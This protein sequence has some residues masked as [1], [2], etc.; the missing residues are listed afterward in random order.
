MG[1][2]QDPAASSGGARARARAG[3]A[4]PGAIPQVRRRSRPSHVAL[5]RLTADGPR[6]RRETRTS[7]AAA[8]LLALGGVDG[9]AQAPKQC[10]QHSLPLPPDA[11]LCSA[12]RVMT[13]S[14]D[15]ASAAEDA[16]TPR[17]LLRVHAVCLSGDEGQDT[18]AAE[19]AAATVAI[20]DPLASLSLSE[21]RAA[22]EDMAGGWKT[23]SKNKG[24][25]RRRLEEQGYLPKAPA[26]PTAVEAL[27][28]AL[29][30]VS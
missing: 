19:G 8:G 16:D 11:H 25:M 6:P 7:C 15:A 4:T 30:E 28:E 29:T 12:G 9:D 24:W 22:F 18:T 26:A 10:R 27:T 1:Q 13:L 23:T 20:V 3:E 14:T 21:L 2:R 5:C 17:S